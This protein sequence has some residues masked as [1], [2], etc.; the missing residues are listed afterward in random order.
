MKTLTVNL[1]DDKIASR[2]TKHDYKFVVAVKFDGSETKWNPLWIGWV[3]MSWHKELNH[4]QRAK[5]AY[6][7]HPLVSITDVQIIPVNP[8][9]DL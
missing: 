6:D 7:V 4:A 1:P 9:K 5:R 2:K 8:T 3:A